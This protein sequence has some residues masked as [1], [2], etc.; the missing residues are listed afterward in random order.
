MQ[1]LPIGVM[2]KLF[3]RIWTVNKFARLHSQNKLYFV[4]VGK[5]G[6]FHEMKQTL[7][8]AD[9]EKKKISSCKLVK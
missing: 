8:Y 5:K 7:S 1:N 3:K 4:T 9:Q 2:I 6:N